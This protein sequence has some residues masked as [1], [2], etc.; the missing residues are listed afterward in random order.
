MKRINNLFDQICSVENLHLADSKARKSKSKQ[1]SILIHDKN[2]EGNI[3]QLH[4]NLMAGSY[5][6][7]AYKTFVIF[8]PKRREIFRLPY[9][10]DRIVHHAIMN[11]L[12][13][14]WVP[15]FTRDT[16]SAIKGRGV[17]SMGDSI[18]MAL[19]DEQETQV[20]P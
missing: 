5:K 14:I 3:L 2:R 19:K 18:R 12:E 20:L 7:S 8:E 9:Y 15:M 11:V 13:P 6:T 10:P 16:Y 17:H 1:H 4:E